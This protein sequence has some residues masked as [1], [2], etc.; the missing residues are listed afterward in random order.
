MSFISVV[1]VEW[2]KGAKQT[3]T[4]KSPVEVHAHVVL[5]VQANI[6]LGMAY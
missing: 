2:R 3:V 1:V 4:R 5:G 6:T